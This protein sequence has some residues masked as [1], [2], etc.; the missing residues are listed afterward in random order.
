M[1]RILSLLFSALL[2]FSLTGCSDWEEPQDAFLE[3]MTQYYGKE[4]KEDDEPALTSFALPYLAGETADPY[5]CLDGAQKTLGTLLYEGLFE[6]DTAFVPQPA[7]AESFQRDENIWYFPSA[8][9]STE[10]SHT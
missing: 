6:L 3:I 8:P 4:Q 10:Q 7:L 2:L 9:L 5:T 1:K